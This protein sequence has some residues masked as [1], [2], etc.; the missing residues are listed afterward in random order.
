MKKTLS[1]NLAFL[2][3]FSILAKTQTYLPGFSITKS[4]DTIKG[5]IEYSGGAINPAKI[6]FKKT[7]L[8]TKVEELTVEN[9]RE[10]S[11]GGV[12]IFRAVPVKISMDT[13]VYSALSVG[14]DNTYKDETVFLK[15]L[16]SGPRLTLYLFKDKLKERYYISMV[17]KA[18]TELIYKVYYDQSKQN[19]IKE[20]KFYQRQL[21]LEGLNAGLDRETLDRRLS[22]VSYAT[23]DI[24]SIVNLINGTSKEPKIQIAKL[25][26]IKDLGTQTNIPFRLFVGGG[27]ETNLLKVNSNGHALAGVSNSIGDNVNPFFI[28]GADI[29]L[30]PILQ[31]TALRV[32]LGFDLAN[33]TLAKFTNTHDMVKRDSLILNWN[34]FSL[35][36]VFLQK[37]NLSRTTNFSLSYGF[38]VKMY[39]YKNAFTKTDYFEGATVYVNE[40]KNKVAKATVAIPLSASFGVGN[41]ELFFRYNLNILPYTKGNY[42]LDSET[43][44]F[45]K[46]RS[47]FRGKTLQCGLM[48]SYAIK[49]K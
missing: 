7:L 18:P 15:Q 12:D 42:E 38:Q 37:F 31:K 35:N 2:F 21:F 5:Y 47:E 9:S 46:G 29:F 6:Q 44:S 24:K 19:Q 41:L 8:D 48:Y 33:N 11:I 25:N 43:D 27:M 28:L 4:G 49:R 10:I 36:T 26:A 16:A 20:D 30:N 22:K 13:R 3:F 39:A 14:E 23:S 1:L 32:E 34:A 17:G 45:T 40:Y